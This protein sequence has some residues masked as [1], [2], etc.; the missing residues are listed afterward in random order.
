VK[1]VAGAS[2]FGGGEARKVSIIA[3]TRAPSSKACAQAEQLRACS[4]ASLYSAFASGSAA[5]TQLG[6]RILRQALIGCARAAHTPH[7]SSSYGRSSA[8]VTRHLTSA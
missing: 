5:N 7:A 2:S 6:P 3:T 1:R 4:V 8:S